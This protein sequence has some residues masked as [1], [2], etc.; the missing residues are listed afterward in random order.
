MKAGIDPGINTRHLSNFYCIQYFKDRSS[1]EQE[2]IQPHPLSRF[3]D[4]KVG[5]FSQPPNFS[6]TFFEKFSRSLIFKKIALLFCED[7]RFVI[8]ISN[9]A[10]FLSKGECKD[11][12][13]F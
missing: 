5:T 7:P 3:A 8:R 2:R 9:F 10:P 1:V 12:A 11:T 4:A 13:S 6:N